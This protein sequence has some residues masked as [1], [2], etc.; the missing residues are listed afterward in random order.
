M[1]FKSFLLDVL[2]RTVNASWYRTVGCSP[3]EAA[4]LADMEANMN[5]LVRTTEAA[6]EDEI[7]KSL[8]RSCSHYNE[9]AAAIAERQRKSREENPWIYEEAEKFRQ[10]ASRIREAAMKKKG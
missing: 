1:N 5:P 10:E 9:T 8:K 7:E 3:E 6:S 2:N 4:F